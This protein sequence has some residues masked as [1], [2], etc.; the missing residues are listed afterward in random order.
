MDRDLIDK[1]LES[2]Q[3]CIIRIKQKTPNSVDILRKDLDLQ[4][5]ITLN[6]EK[7]IHNCVDISLHLLSSLEVK[8]PETMAESF[9]LLNTKNII[10]EDLSIRMI[11]AVGF[12]N[13]AVHTYQ[14]L[15]YDIIFSLIT[16]N[17]IDFE[18]FAK[19]ICKLII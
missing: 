10:S 9:E 5:I 1:K 11:K 3:R 13:I 4:D 6:L 2:L 19:S 17:L 14:D 8:T 18:L 12:R 7:A 15:D 16:K